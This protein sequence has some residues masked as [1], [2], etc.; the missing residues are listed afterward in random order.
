MKE[1]LTEELIA[2]RAAKELKPGDY[3][4]LGLGTPQLCASYVPPEVYVQTE[5]GALGFG[6]LVTA[7]NWEQL[8]TDLSDAGGRFFS[9]APGMSFFDMLTSFNMIR[10]GRLTTILG[11]LQVS[12]KGDLAIH[13]TSED[14]PYPQIGGAMD[15]AWG[16]K[17]LIVAMAHNTKDGEPKIVKELTLPLSAKECIDLIITDLAVIEVTGEGLVLKEFAPEWTPKEVQAQTGAQLIVA[18]DVKEVE[19]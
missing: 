13:S 18:E 15:L 14:D 2:M 8:D 9:P 12:E 16:A 10:S 6:P 5:N 11:G 4:N 1:R 7:D 19:F 3:C 17:R